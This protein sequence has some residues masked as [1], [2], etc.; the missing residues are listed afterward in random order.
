MED[1]RH[2]AELAGF[3][4]LARLTADAKLPVP[5]VPEG[6][7]IRY[8]YSMPPVEATHYEEVTADNDYILY[9]YRLQEVAEGQLNHYQFW[10]DGS[11]EAYISGEVF[12]AAELE[13]ESEWMSD[14]TYADTIDFPGFEEARFVPAD[15]ED[16]ANEYLL[17]VP[18]E[19]AYVYI[20]TSAGV[21]I[22]TVLA[23]FPAE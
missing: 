2:D 15:Y 13:A 10:L 6:W 23:L 9:K 17:T 14:F 21:P 19:G 8:I 1:R 11:D 20:R 22:E 4:E 12:P 3:D 16:D 7:N 18:G 5:S